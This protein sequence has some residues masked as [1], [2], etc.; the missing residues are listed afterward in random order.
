MYLLSF[1]FLYKLQGRVGDGMGGWGGLGGG[2]VIG[3][4]CVC[5]AMECMQELMSWWRARGTGHV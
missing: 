3:N 1:T 5:A 2:Q 4:V